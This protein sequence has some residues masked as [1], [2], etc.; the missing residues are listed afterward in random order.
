MN[1]QNSNG[2]F[3]GNGSYQG[4]T[5]E[6]VF[7]SGNEQAA[8]STP[9]RKNKSGGH[10]V[11]LVFLTLVLCVSFSFA[12][13][14]GGAW[15]AY[16]LKAEEQAPSDGDVNKAHVDKHSKKSNFTEITAAVDAMKK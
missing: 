3:F 12:A 9:P 2:N 5:Y 15:L 13:G 7:S 4:N 6:Y 16:T 11:A 1:G 10:R 14:F 8:R